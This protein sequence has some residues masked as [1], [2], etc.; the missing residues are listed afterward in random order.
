M[1]ILQYDIVYPVIILL[2]D[3]GV[4]RSLEVSGSLGLDTSS[5]LGPCCGFRRWGW[6]FEG[7]QER[8]KPETPISLI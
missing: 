2:G 4:D 7:R 3:V 8:N 6:R 5:G 1:T